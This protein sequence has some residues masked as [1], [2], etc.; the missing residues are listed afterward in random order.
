M[1]DGVDIDLYADVDHEFSQEE[2][3]GFPSSMDLYDDM[4]QPSGRQGSRQQI[5]NGLSRNNSFQYNYQG[6]KVSIYVGNLTWWTTD[7]DVQNAI[8][9]LGVNDLVEIKFFEN[10]ANGQSKGFALVHL[11]SENSSRLIME[12]LP[13]KDIHGQNPLVTLCT[14]Q[15][16]NQFEQQSKAQSGNAP[17]KPPTP[18]SQPSIFSQP[19]PALPGSAQLSVPPP[20]PPPTTQTSI[21][22]QPPPNTPALP[23]PPPHGL[24]PA[25]RDLLSQ[26]RPPITIPPP[27]HGLPITNG[28]PPSIPPPSLHG[29]RPPNMPPPPLMA[30]ARMPPPPLLVPPNVNTRVPPPIAIP[31]MPPPSL[32]SVP[33]P[34]LL[35]QLAAVRPPTNIP[36][37]SLPNQPTGSNDVGQQRNS[38]RGRSRTPPTSEAD[39]EA[40]NRNRAVSSTAISRAVADASSGD[41]GSAIETLV[42]AISLL[43]QSKVADDERTKVLIGSLRDCL[44]GIEEKSFGHGSSGS[45]RRDRSHDREERSRYRERESKSRRRDR[46]RDRSRSRDR[47]EERDYRDRSRERD[48][49]SGAYRHSDRHRR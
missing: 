39:E 30:G 19:P 24:P 25:A 17:P 41:Y 38:Y 18:V 26:I 29:L 9:N 34:N 16:L 32:A 48:G 46:E 21:L 33:P 8:Q 15:S 23:F 45:K 10:R 13:H 40:M 22:G 6:K 1:A 31:G 7:D 43:R 42:T 20:I 47:Y 37:P 28:P 35:S 49:G 27:R 2:S 11:A 3:N 12:K 36:P 4:V 14:R 5:S 44:N